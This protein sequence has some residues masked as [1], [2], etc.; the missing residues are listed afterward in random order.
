M[1]KS[2]TPLTEAEKKIIDFERIW[3]KFPGVKEDKIRAEFGISPTRYYQQ[4]NALV[5]RPEALTYDP[6]TVRRIQRLL[7]ARVDLRAGQAPG[8]ATPG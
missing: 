7:K 2:T 5:R 6:S 1:G 4:R 3:W 8:V